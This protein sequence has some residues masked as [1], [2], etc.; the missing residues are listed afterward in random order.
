MKLLF[1]TLLSFTLFFAFAQDQNESKY[2]M[3]SSSS[4]TGL[5]IGDEAPDFVTAKADGSDYSL[6]EDLRSN[7]VVLIFYRGYWCGYCTR[8]LAAFSDSLALLQENG[9]DVVAVT[10]E[11]YDY[12][13]ETIEKADVTFTILSD[14]D[15]SVMRAY[16]VE[17]EVTDA[18][19]DKIKNYKGMSLETINGQ[20]DAALPIPATY[21]VVPSKD[22]GRIAWRHFDPD[23][24][25]RASVADILDAY[26]GMR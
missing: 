17:F 25:Q 26:D 3:E 14:T 13:D 11:T 2:G 5:N 18:Y 7:A 9:I 15:G 8:E 19:N 21:L 12:V 16:D 24:S 22:G 1:T 6:S 20:D 10:P 4:P 23:Y